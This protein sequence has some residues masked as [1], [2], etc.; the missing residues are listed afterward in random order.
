MLWITAWLTDNVTGGWGLHIDEF[1]WTAIW[2][3]ILL[4]IVSWLL[5]LL[6]RDTER[7]RARRD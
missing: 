7:E 5:G 2:A 4:S 3:A 6:V 1:W